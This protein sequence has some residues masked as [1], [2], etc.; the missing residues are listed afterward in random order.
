MQRSSSRRS[1][2]GAIL[3]NNNALNEKVR[4]MK[5]F[6]FAGEDDVIYIGTNGK[7]N[8]V[9]AAM[10]LTSLESIDHFIEVNRRNY[11]CYRDSL[12]D[13]PGIQFLPCNE[14]EQNN[15]QYIIIEIDESQA[16]LTRDQLKTILKAE[17]V[18][19]RSYF[20]PGCH[21][22]EPYRTLCPQAGLKLPETERVC[23]RVM[24]LPN[25]TSITPSHTHRLC[26]L[27]RFSLKNADAI[28]ERWPSHVQM[29]AHAS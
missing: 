25:G 8:E 24:V 2:G 23:R 5:N 3:T 14:S 20:N 27:I 29:L 18:L 12:A 9:S 17:H 19:A 28:A 21:R 26:E 6:G 15:Y 11:E 22:M 10:G 16:V 1:R 4:L 13:M 7:M